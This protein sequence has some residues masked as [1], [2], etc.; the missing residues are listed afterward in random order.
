MYKYMR[1]CG[2]GSVE[3][4]LSYIYDTLRWGEFIWAALFQ[5]VLNAIPEYEFAMP[6]P[7]SEIM[8]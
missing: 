8:F 6:M 3:R 1:D 2:R 7:S 4:D 5:S